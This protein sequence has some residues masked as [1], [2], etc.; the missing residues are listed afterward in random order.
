MV[1]KK[2]PLNFY[3]LQYHSFWYN[4]YIFNQPK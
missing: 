2:K 1:K 4:L 3:K